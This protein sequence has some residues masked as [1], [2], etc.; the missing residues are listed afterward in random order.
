MNLNMAKIAF[1]ELK[2]V[3]LVFKYAYSTFVIFLIHSDRKVSKL[4]V[5]Q[6]L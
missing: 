3:L 5:T 4:W 6:I 1:R 2:D